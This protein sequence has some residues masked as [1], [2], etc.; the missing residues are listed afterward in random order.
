M[1]NETKLEIIQQLRNG[2]KKYLNLDDEHCYIYNNKWEKINDKN[3]YVVIGIEDEDI[4]ANNLH[5]SHSEDGEKLLST[6]AVIVATKFFIDCFSY[7]LEA[8]KRR[9]EVVSY[10]SS[11]ACEFMQEQMAYRVYQIPSLF[12]DISSTEGNKVLNRFKVEFIVH[13]SQ[14]FTVDTPYYD[15][16]GGRGFIINN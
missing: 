16:I 5:Y 14:E 7:S 8:R 4:L 9:F 2:I 15:T 1:S 12:K 10:L 13:H 3:M 6:S 11:D